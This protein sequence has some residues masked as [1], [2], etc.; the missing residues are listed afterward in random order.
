[1]VTNF[2]KSDVQSQSARVPSGAG[3]DSVTPRALLKNKLRKFVTLQVFFFFFVFFAHV[4]NLTMTAISSTDMQ[5]DDV[6]HELRFV[7]TNDIEMSELRGSSIG[8]DIVDNV[9]GPR[10]RR[11]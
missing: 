2:E 10:G 3:S 6:K 7:N 4:R 5:L 1:M 9:V 11:G 8:G